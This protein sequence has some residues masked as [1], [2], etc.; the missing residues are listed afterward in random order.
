MIRSLHFA[1]LLLLAILGPRELTAETAERVRPAL[2]EGRYADA[3][4]DA[5]TA[6]ARG[7]PGESGGLWQLLGDALG[8]DALVLGDAAVEDTPD[9]IIVSC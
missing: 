4:A 8:T 3:I 5:R 1:A 6:L 7:Q 9:A 2:E